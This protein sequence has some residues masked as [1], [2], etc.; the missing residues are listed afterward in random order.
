[1][2]SH[3]LPFDEVLHGLEIAATPQSAKVMIQFEE[4]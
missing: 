3:T 2:I 4:A 1:M